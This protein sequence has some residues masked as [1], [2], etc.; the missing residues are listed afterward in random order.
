M[1]QTNAPTEYDFSGLPSPA[2]SADGPATRGTRLLL[3]LMA[4]VLGLLSTGLGV[5]L[6]AFADHDI[7][8]TA[9]DAQAALVACTGGDTCTPAQT[10]SEIVYLARDTGSAALLVGAGL[11]AAGLTLVVWN[12]LRRTPS[13]PAGPET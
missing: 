4:P 6:R 1:T 11:I 5:V 8:S 7:A 9:S 12:A 3:L 2:A 13:S 10:A